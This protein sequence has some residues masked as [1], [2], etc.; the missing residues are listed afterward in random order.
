MSLRNHWRIVGGIIDLNLLLLLGLLS[1]RLIFDF[2]FFFF[3]SHHTI[4]R[5]GSH[6]IADLRHVNPDIHILV[7]HDGHL[8]R[9]IA[10]HIHHQI[11]LLIINDDL[12]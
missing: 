6:L 9:L 10:L 2:N 11:I 4:L 5:N 3:F 12:T 1:G 7:I 8:L